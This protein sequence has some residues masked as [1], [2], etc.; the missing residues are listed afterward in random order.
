[1]RPELVYNRRVP[2][3]P[4]DD[5]LTGL[6]F[7]LLERYGLLRHAAPFFARESVPRVLDVGGATP[8]LWEGF[9]T[10]AGEWLPGA[11]AV[12][13]DPLPG[14]G[15][16]PYVR[17]RAR[18]LPFP[19]ASFDLVAS[20]DMLEHL[21]EEERAPSLREM[22]RVTRDG[23]LV[24][25]PYDSPANRT[26]EKLLLD[27]VAARFHTAI[28]QLE[29]HRAMGLPDRAQVESFLASTGCAV[30]P[31]TQGNADVW[32]LMMMAQ[33][34]LRLSGQ[35]ALVE[36]LNRRFNAGAAAND[37]AEP[38]YR[39]G[40]L[41][42]KRRTASELED[43]LGRFRDPRGETTQP[44][45]ILPL[46]QLLLGGAPQAAGAAPGKGVEQRL[47]SLERRLD[48][49]SHRVSAILESRT[50]RTLCDLGARAARLG[51]KLPGAGDRLQ[52]VCDEPVAGDPTPWSG[53]AAVKGW[54]LARS[55]VKSVEIQVDGAPPQ[56]AHLGG[57]RPDVARLH[58]DVK[59][60]ARSGFSLH[61]DSASLE[62]GPHNL[63]IRAVSAAGQ[64]R[65]L[66]IP[67]HVLQE[68][69]FESDYHRWIEQYEKDA[70]VALAGP[71][72]L[73]SVLTPVHDPAPS[74][75]KSA[76]ASVRAQRYENWELCLADD[77]STSPEVAAVLREAS[78]Q[79]PR[80]RV[81]RL[82][83][84]GGVSAA[85]NAA[86]AM[87]QGEYV[88]LLDH[89]DELA[90]HALLRMA[91]AVSREPQAALY[92]SDEDLL[93][94]LG[95]R[96]SPFFKPDWSPDLLLSENYICH[97]LMAPAT[98]VREAG[99]FRSEYDGS[100]DYDLI[101]RLTRLG[102]PIVHVPEV[103]YHWREGA[104]S[105]ALEPTSK[106]YAI[107]AARRALEDHLRAAG[108]QARVVEGV[109][110]GRWRVRYPIPENAGVSVL[111][112][113]G[114]K[115]DV[116]RRNLDALAS[117]TDYRDFEV[118]VIDNSRGP[119]I[120]RLVRRWR[121]DGVEAR[122]LD[123][124]GRSFNYSA[125][126]NEAVKSCRRPLLLFLNDDTEALDPGWLTALV[127]LA[128]RPEV[129]AA[130][131]KLLYPDGRIQHAGV[132]LGVYGVA[133]HSFRGL[134][135]RR[136]HYFDFP[137]VIR[138]VSA[139]TAACLMLR[140]SVFEEAGGFDERALA[141][142]F[143]D[144]DLCLRIGR[145]GYRVLYTPYALLTHYEAFS[146]NERDVT[147]HAAEVATMETRWGGILANDPFYSPNLSRETEAYLCR[148]RL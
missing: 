39:A 90:S 20:F 31:F 135:G 146:K 82:E 72:P 130:G 42:S 46:C 43:L 30:V 112:A 118:V 81:T 12:A 76:I 57:P 85:T 110:P 5:K 98:L 51:R 99:G 38:A 62:N 65:E 127:E 24:L 114:G 22:L 78:R 58:P 2:S 145:R 26:V 79:D 103:L 29:E 96:H 40:A 117:R 7:D 71:Q 53:L 74:V 44:A 15:L 21:P 113:S 73:I 47:D 126:H 70:A 97:L 27:F 63:R 133:G 137:D 23:L 141:V 54:A 125:L 93:D 102:R 52:L 10:L 116:L 25:Y 61:I 1:M 121:G 140:R 18:A 83:R 128:V 92:Y 89:D 48:F 41:V 136:Q 11:F 6:A 80:I 91:E 129:G 142:A 50:W 109:A 16:R 49:L 68:R 14:R 100:Q 111:I 45:A 59:D 64:V 19:D 134:D 67:V 120:E 123:M 108:V 32:L 131:A 35:G 28:P 105:A 33:H 115:V 34:S 106:S 84:S 69:T 104:G 119:E 88:A 55:G 148:H 3:L 122:L 132:A 9:T 139:V 86:L 66:E 147:P 8:P 138:N 143:N 56:L 95:R 17:A 94:S 13:A 87:A 36:S 144:I 4:A 60:A 124:R 77:A 37:W 101:L 107:D 75:L